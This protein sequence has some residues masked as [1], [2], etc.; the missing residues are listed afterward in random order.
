MAAVASILICGGIPLAFYAVI[1]VWLP[2]FRL[3]ANWM[4]LITNVYDFSTG[5]ISTYAIAFYLV[6]TGLSLFICSK[7][8]VLLRLRS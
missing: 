2:E 1:L 7:T 4:P 6:L 8:L 5:L 3:N